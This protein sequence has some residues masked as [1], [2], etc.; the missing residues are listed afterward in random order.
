VTLYPQSLLW[1][2]LLVLVTALVLS[3]AAAVYILDQYVTRPRAAVG[4]RQFVSHLKTVSAALET[5]D[6]SQHEAFIGR[7]LEMEGIRITPVREDMAVRPA[8]DVPLTRAFRERLR[9]S[10]GPN[11]EVYVR[12]ASADPEEFSRRPPR[13][14]FI[15]LTA[16][17]RQYWVAIPR[18]RL[19]RDTGTAVL[20]WSLA[21]LGIAVLATF[22]IVW[23]LNRPLGELARAAGKL[24]RGGDPEPVR[25]S[26]PSEIRAVAR[27]FNQMKEGLRRAERDRAT[28]LAGV[29]HDLRT[30]L[31]RLR[32]GV[33]MLEGKA[34]DAALEGMVADIDDMGKIVDQFIDFTRG[35]AGEALSAVNLSELARAC[36]E[37]AARAG[38]AVS[39]ELAQTTPLMLRP[40]AIQRAIDNLI[41][42]AARHAGGAIL[43][44][45]CNDPDAVVVEVLDRGPGIP[46]ELREHVKQP[47]ARLDSSR[48][49]QSGAGLGLAIADR[50]AKLHG[51]RLDLAG[52]DGGGLAARLVL[53]RA[54][55][56][57]LENP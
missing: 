6:P 9:D 28:F 2:T 33:E 21:G 18:G 24:G 37:R 44:R 1:R 4:M 53:P 27:A 11:A 57:E 16:G 25:E 19:D 51:G 36:C 15:K 7:V 42:N 55:G 54:G 38:A 49:G 12:P 46:A 50:I 56:G 5:L 26:G 14:F 30:P 43:V 45:T 10:F 22:L 23:R 8:P 40:L 48:T 13:L 29:S 20:A 31:A 41:T 3:Q 35:E 52:R 34:G 39:C 17:Q 47:F 32:L